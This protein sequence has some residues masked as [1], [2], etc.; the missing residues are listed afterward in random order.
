MLRGGGCVA[1]TAQAVGQP[2]VPDRLMSASQAELTRPDCR[3]N[4]SGASPKNTPHGKKGKGKGKR[5]TPS[6]LVRIVARETLF[7]DAHTQLVLG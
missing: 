3:A 6:H 2:S 1:R 4:E 5:K 7:T